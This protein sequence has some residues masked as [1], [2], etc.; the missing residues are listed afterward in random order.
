MVFADRVQGWVNL[1]T[2]I[3]AKFLGQTFAHYRPLSTS[4][5][6]QPI[7][8]IEELFLSFD[9][10]PQF[11]YHKPKEY[12]DQI[13]FALCDYTNVQIGDYFWNYADQTFF[14]S[15]F[16]QL[17]PAMLMRCNRIVT[18]QRPAAAAGVSNGYG[19]N[20]S[21]V[22]LLNGWPCSIVSGGIGGAN[23]AHTPGSVK[24]HGVVITFPHYVD[25]DTYDIVIDDANRRY[26]VGENERTALGY[27]CLAQYESA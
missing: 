21:P 5:V 25:V 10:D 2:G 11:S 1:G 26:V 6:L 9:Q 17:K 22:T 23:D 27:R 7:N 16:E 3:A 24:D 20:T 13:Y 4:T 15:N 19:S 8:M 14:V 18:V 12:G